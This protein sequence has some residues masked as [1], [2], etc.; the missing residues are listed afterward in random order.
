MTPAV[1]TRRGAL[2]LLLKAAASATVLRV[3]T[4]GAMLAA[5][6]ATGLDAGAI[7]LLHLDQLARCGPDA[8]RRAAR[9]RPALLA[10]AR[11]QSGKTGPRAAATAF[12]LME[13]IGEFPPV[14]DPCGGLQ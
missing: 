9:L 5:S 12:A 6:T 14:L 7:V 3:A 11:Q 1:C 8:A 13:H 2:L 4:P 10:A